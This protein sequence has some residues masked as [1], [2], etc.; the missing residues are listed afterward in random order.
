MASMT[1]ACSSKTTCNSSNSFRERGTDM[2]V[3]YHWLKEFTPISASPDEL[4]SQL[5][6]A[7]LEVESLAAVAPPFSGVVVG[8]V[9][10]TGRH[11][12]AEKLSLCQATT[13]GKKRLQ[14]AC[15]A[16]N[17]PCG[18]KVG[19]GLARSRLS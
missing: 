3:T 1:C 11:P 5:T 8:Q 17:V 16:Q 7:G 18:L 15:G 4:A 19:V 12:D 2:K 6:M 10:E 9:L 13:D 14:I